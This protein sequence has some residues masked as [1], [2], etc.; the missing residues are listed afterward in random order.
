MFVN[1]ASMT[2][3]GVCR[4]KKMMCE[5]RKETETRNSGKRV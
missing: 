3:A 5:S 4:G 2:T 1:K